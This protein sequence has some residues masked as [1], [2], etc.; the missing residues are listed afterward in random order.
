MPLAV[1]AGNYLRSERRCEL[2]NV[3]C[4][5]DLFPVKQSAIYKGSLCKYPGH[6]TA[7]C[8]QSQGKHLLLF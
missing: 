3:E 4:E 7:E 6:F 1:V 8:H 5:V 2:L